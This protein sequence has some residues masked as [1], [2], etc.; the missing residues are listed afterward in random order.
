MRPVARLAANSSLYL[1]I[2]LPLRNTNALASL[3]QDICDPASPRFRQYLTPEQFTEQ[4]GP[5]VE[6]YEK[7]AAYAAANNLKITARHSN[8]MLLDVRAS[9]A[10]VER[11]FGVTLRTYR[12]PNESRDFFA[13]DTPPT[14]A[15]DL[16]ILRVSGL[17]NYIVPHPLDL[18]IRPADVASNTTVTPYSLNGSGPGGTYT[19]KDF[20][21]AYA[22]GVT[23]T[24]AGQYI[25]IVD[26][27]GPYYTNDV[28]MYQT[29]SGFTNTVITNIL[30][31]GWTGIPV[32]TNQDDGEEVLDIDM[33]MSLAPGA[34]ILNY[35][36]EAHDVF[37]QIAIDN[38]AKQMTLSY[39]FGIDET[40]RQ[41]F[42]QFVAQ[43]QSFFQASGDGGA[44]LS[45][46]GGLTG[47]PYATI[48]G[49]TALS[50]SGA[51]GPWSG[52]TTWIGSGGGVSSYGIPPWQEGINMQTNQGSAVFRNYP[53]VA[54]LADTAIFIYFKNGQ[55]L[56]GVGGTSAS[57][58]QWAGFMALVNESAATLGKPSVGFANPAI[59]A[60]GKGAYLPYTNAFHDI[61]TGNTVNNHNPLVY[62]ATNGYDLCTGWGSPRGSNTITALVAV[63]TNDF[64]LNASQVG[65]NLVR[66]TTAST[67]VR[68]IPMNGFSGSANLSVSGLPT[69]VTP[70]FT[71]T[72]ITTGTAILTL[73]A[74]SSV[75]P[76]S[77]NVTLTAVSGA[78]TRSMTLSVV[79]TAPIPNATNVNLAS[80]YNRAGIFSDGQTFS[81]GLDT[82]GS[83][84]SASLLGRA[85]AWQGV[86]FPVGPS[87]A[88]DVISASGQ[89]I[90]LPS[91]QATT[92]LMLAATVNG[93]QNTQTFTITYTDN[94]TSVLTQGISDWASPQ[95]YAGESVVATMP[96]RD[97]GGG[98]KD[99]NTRVLVYGYSL[100]LNQ[101]KAVKSITL[102]NNSKV[103]MLAMALVNEPAAA[104]LASYFN[105]AGMYTDGTTFTNPATGGA[106]GGGAAYSATLLGS[107]LTWSN[108]LFNFGPANA[109]NVISSANQTLTLPPGRYSTLRML[110]SGLQGNQVSQSFVV[111]YTDATTSTFIQSMSDWFTPQN[112]PGESK[113]FAC[114]HRNSS[115]G[116]LDNRTFYV[117]GY[118]F[119]LNSGKTVQSIRLPS[120]ANVLVLAISMIPD[121]PPSFTANPFA[122]AGL[123]AGQAIS[124]TI[125]T[126]ATDLNG[127]AITFGKVSG[128]SWLNVAANGLLSGTPGNSDAGTDIFVVSAT[129]PGG[130]SNV[131]TLTIY[132]NG[133]PSFI[134]NPFTMPGINAGQLYSGTVATNATDPNGDSITFAKVSGPA[135]LNVAANGALSGLPANSDAGINS[136]VV[137][138]ADPAGLSNNATMYIYV[139]G[140]PSF[141]SD[142]F[143]APAAA[144]TQPYSGTIAAAATDPNGD[145]LSFAKVSGPAWLIIAA[146]GTLSGTPASTDIGTNS[147]VVSATDPGALSATAAMNLI[148]TP[149]PIVASVSL[150]DTN[151]V[152]SWT[153]GTAPFQVQTAT[154]LSS[155]AWQ[156]LLGPLNTNT[157]TLSTNAPAMFYRILGQQ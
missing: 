31:S 66:G 136:F 138:A 120:N 44:D 47:E 121:W 132:V 95:N 55:S 144:A 14:V 111:T 10:D 84:Y 77:N 152:L 94:S 20:R 72:T 154:N 92:L 43:G 49:G 122:V 110:A 128:P 65:L 135:W 24:G 22:P 118:S 108:I 142:P 157:V 106:D 52:E 80:Y 26:V 100:V 51:G 57:S 70:S 40:I 87:N 124:G 148:V 4:F 83:S 27:G 8:R 97:G 143:I 11:T 99:L 18:R 74:G 36:G 117:Y 90:T 75:L 73:A 115:N 103:I 104:S 39:G 126:N 79:V 34:T 116:S 59:Y 137:S 146:D 53:D 29:N 54:M 69:G 129:D 32:G 12:H 56:Q 141:V 139:N 93:S 123:N 131:A 45:G 63:G 113:A 25:A 62:N 78:M 2:G 48:V 64:I 17:D 102:P 67:I 46:G 37:N 13:S 7:V 1:V 88:L 28:Y 50:T 41:I 151:L 134:N 98:T 85:I 19:G 112:Y 35:E 114:G 5:T 81:G 130:L 15:A 149:A 3:L 156:N 127:D 60:L 133:A 16:P 140:A 42:L 105:R 68:V 33:S 89:T 145:P 109:T 101:T 153:G 61:T 119:N 71:A 6:D 91:V 23:N 9:V 82:V 38:K 21:A 58:P 96:Y 147:F 125:A 150:A 30:L 155:P 86:S 76:G 107:S